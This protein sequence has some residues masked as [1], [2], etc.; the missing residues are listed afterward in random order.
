[1][2]CA[3]PGCRTTF[4]LDEDGR[5]RNHSTSRRAAAQEARAKGG[6]VTG[7]RA[8]KMRTVAPDQVPNGKPP[9]TLD[10]CITWAS[11][12]AF[13][14]AT[15]LLDGVTVREVNR[16][17]GTLKVA[18]EKK[19]LVDRVRALEKSLKEFERERPT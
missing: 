14:A 8:L 17:L 11:W 19:Q 10:D 6:A 2:T 5:C 16:S 9:E 15:G 18:L 7:A 12:C 13:A 4:G 1:M 3:E